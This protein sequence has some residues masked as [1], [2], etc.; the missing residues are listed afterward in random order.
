MDD[1]KTLLFVNMSSHSNYSVSEPSNVTYGIPQ[2]FQF[3]LL[4]M[5]G[6]TCIIVIFGNGI[7]CFTTYKVHSFRTVTN[8]F[9]VS[10]A[11]TD[12]I[13][14]VTCVPFTILSNLFFHYW[15]FGAFMCPVVGFIQL[16]SVLLRSFMLVAMTC[17]RY[18]VAR[19]PLKP[20]LLTK[21]RAKVLVAII[22]ALSSLIA[23]PTFLYSKITYMPYEPGSRGLCMET[24]P[25]D[26][27]RSLYGVCIM[28]LQ[29]F[30]PLLIMSVTYIH[31]G[32]IIWVKRTPG[33]AN[34]AR[35]A[36]MALSKKKVNTQ[37]TIDN[38]TSPET[39]VLF[40]KL[41]LHICLIPFTERKSM[42]ICPHYAYD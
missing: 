26:S 1:S 11:V 6:V 14:T 15:P 7:V 37:R 33:E 31:I 13:M 20:R 3:I 24:W 17:D 21:C 16:A 30:V 8:F 27:T 36:R 22:S 2:E 42:Y 29:Y 12:I 4:G 41:L 32:I 10:L 19:K 18:H 25:D 35:D 34:S 23:L 40:N 28:M 9:I 39:K 38:C 5:Y